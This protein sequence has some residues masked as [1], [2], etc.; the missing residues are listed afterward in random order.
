MKYYNSL[1]KGHPE[2]GS[3]S[4]KR[5]LLPLTQ[6]NQVLGLFRPTYY[7]RS[8]LASCTRNTITIYAGLQV[9]IGGELFFTDVDKTI[10]VDS[11]IS[12]SNRAGKD[13]YIYA[14]KSGDAESFSPDFV[15]SLN[16][17]APSGYTTSNSRKIGGFHCLCVGVGTNQAIVHPMYGFATG[18]I[19]PYSMWDLCH[20]PES[21]PEGMSFIAPIGIW[22]DIY[23][24]SWNGS[25]LVSVYNGTIADGLTKVGSLTG[26]SGD[27]FVERF[28]EVNK[29]L[30][31]RDEFIV[32]AQGTPELVNIMGSSDPV[33]TGGHV[34]TNGLRCVSKYGIEDCCGVIWQYIG[35]QYEYYPDYSMPSDTVT[36]KFLTGYNWTQESDY[37]SGSDSD[38]HGN[39]L[40]ILRR[41]IVGGCYKNGDNCGP[42]CLA[43]NAFSS[44]KDGAVSSR[45]VSAPRR[46][47]DI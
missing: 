22:M 40:G 24:P 43:A 17:S 47:L 36:N 18:D 33:T 46:N 15:V 6:L 12:A 8:K 5:I 21:D 7:N 13:V 10:A 42:R 2:N 1:I 35:D 14:C 29:R 39:V 27:N 26:F 34:M 38:R 37:N 25:K 20:L 31:T 16:S 41:G 19:L 9:A 4:D 11:F 45:G 3:V 32:A 30:M 44:Y 23:G 28:A